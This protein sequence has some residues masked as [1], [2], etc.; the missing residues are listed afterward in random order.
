[1]RV[2]L[3]CGSAWLG[4]III[5]GKL[6]TPLARVEAAMHQWKLRVLRGK[7]RRCQLQSHRN[8]R[9]MKW[10]TTRKLNGDW[11]MCAVLEIPGGW[12]RWVTRY[13]RGGDWVRRGRLRLAERLGEDADAESG[14]PKL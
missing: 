10:T 8:H 11:V 2:L 14:R 6:E 4:L 3:E 13:V 7:L 12:V 9:K 5:S 1:M